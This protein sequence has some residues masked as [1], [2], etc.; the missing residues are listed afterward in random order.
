M[1]GNLLLGISMMNILESITQ[2]EEMDQNAM[3]QWGCINPPPAKC[4]S[5][6]NAVFVWLN[7]QYWFY[8]STITGIISITALML[9]IL[10]NDFGWIKIHVKGID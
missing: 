2:L 4:N 7:Q 8:Y 1:I 10:N 3:I 9:I 5:S 6:T